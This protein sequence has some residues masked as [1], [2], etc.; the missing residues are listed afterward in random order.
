MLT[1][2]A[3]FG[4]SLYGGYGDTEA[5]AATLIAGLISLIFVNR[6]RS[7]GIL[8][9]L[10]PPNHAFWWVVCGALGFLAATLYFPYWRACFALER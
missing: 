5:R 3:V 7:G 10:R 1:V 6:S 8:D 2:L 4:V 9:A